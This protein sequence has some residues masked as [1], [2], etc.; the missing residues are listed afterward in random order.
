MKTQE[1]QSLLDRIHLFQVE[2]NIE[3]AMFGV[4]GEEDELQEDLQ[5]WASTSTKICDLAESPHM[6]L[7]QSRVSTFEA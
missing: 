4:V 7:I 1:L 2:S 6:E 5:A 3:E